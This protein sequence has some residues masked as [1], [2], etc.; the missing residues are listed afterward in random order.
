MQP[1]Q[2]TSQADVRTDV[3][4][5]YAKQLGSHLGHKLPVQVAGDTTRI[6][7]PSGDCLL[8][9]GDGVLQMRATAPSEEALTRIEEVVGRHLEKF[10]A[11]AG[12]VVNWVR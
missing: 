5:R 3:P 2:L 1:V 4:A 6:I 11:R 8:V 12:L 7:F 9:P 10:G